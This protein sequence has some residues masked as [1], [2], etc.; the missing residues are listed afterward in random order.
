[1]EFNFVPFVWNLISYSQIDERKWKLEETI[2]RPGKP[3]GRKF[4]MQGSSQNRLN[5]QNDGWKVFLTVEKLQP[6]TEKKTVTDFETLEKIVDFASIAR[7]DHSCFTPTAP[8]NRL[9]Y[10]TVASACLLHAHK[11]PNV[12]P[13]WIDRNRPF[14]CWLTAVRADWSEITRTGCCLFRKVRARKIRAHSR[15]L[16]LEREVLRPENLVQSQLC[17]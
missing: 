4:G 8:G 17:A 9:R 16:R 2:E 11:P 3:G 1:M 5:R 15:I 13:I 7:S 14:V 12:W 10:Y 6:S